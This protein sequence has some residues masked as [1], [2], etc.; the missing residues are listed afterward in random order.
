M[1]TLRL[2]YVSPL[3][4]VRS[5]I[6]DY[7]VD[8]LPQL[9][10]LAEVRVLALPGQP[11]AREVAARWSP[12]PAER[13]GEEGRLPLYHMGNNPYH[14]GVAE[15]AMSR[16]GVLVLHDL[17]LHHFVLHTTLGQR[18]W[19]PYEERLIADHGWVGAAAC[20]LR[21]LSLED[22]A[23]LF[24]L[25][26]HRRL[27]RR[28]L[29]VVVHSRWAAE[30]I[31]DD[32][33]EIAVEPV[34]MGIPLPPPADLAAGRAFRT[35]FGIPL[36][37]PVLGSF[38]FQTPIKRTAAV[39]AALADPRLCE[40]HL[41][42]VGELSPELDFEAL[43]RAAGVAERVHVTG[44]VPYEDFEAAIAAV[45]LC[46]NLRYPTAGET[47]AS[48]LRVLALGRPAVVSDYG[49]FAELPPEV[50]LRVPL[51][52]GEAEGLAAA[53]CDLLDDPERLAT[54]GAEARAYVAAEHDP[55]AAAAALVAACERLGR[56]APP[57]DH[58][59][60]PPPPTSLLWAELPGEIHLT[61]H[62][63]P[64]PAGERRR[65]TVEVEN[66]GPARWL[67]A[68]RGPGGMAL[69]VR[70]SAEVPVPPRPWLPLPRDLAAGES[71]RFEVDLR[72]PPGPVVLDLALRVID[73][74]GAA[75]PLAAT[76]RLALELPGWPP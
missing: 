8:L 2:D 58:P 64:W 46:L 34:P 31:R 68:E 59:A 15:L 25:P 72:R 50:A 13:V 53:L 41:V 20:R 60:S 16:P 61:G 11:V 32:D 27:L 76:P 3:P 75:V 47:S 65:L 39:I 30:M 67:A 73:R 56:L 69:E 23:S 57:G 19:E 71:A 48:L 1:N 42:I 37:R 44:F 52:E 45:D 51:G 54:M 49:Q 14:V 70:L 24:G 40:V 28:Q 22:E 5:G 66:R 43:A 63:P 36:D 29:G 7:S 35:R 55:A 18:V 38:G 33:P 74:P 12:V 4:P 21:S 17:V 26:V 9:A 10:A 6:A 62:E